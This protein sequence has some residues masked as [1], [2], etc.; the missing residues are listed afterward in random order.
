MVDGFIP[1]DWITTEKAAMWSGYGVGYIRRLARCGAIEA[2]KVGRMW[3]ISMTSLRQYV[4]R[5]IERDR[6]YGPNRGW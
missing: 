2:Q 6:R 3:Y 5:A 1:V 4:D